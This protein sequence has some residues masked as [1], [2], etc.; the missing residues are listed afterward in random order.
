MKI[1]FCFGVR[2]QKGNIYF[3]L[4]GK[5]QTKETQEHLALLLTGSAVTSHDDCGRLQ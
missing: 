5:M 1:E 2:W 4:D 3:D